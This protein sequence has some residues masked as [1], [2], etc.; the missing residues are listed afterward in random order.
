M[1]HIMKPFVLSTLRRILFC[2]R[3]QVVCNIVD[4]YALGNVTYCN[5]TQLQFISNIYKNYLYRNVFNTYAF[6]IILNT[7]QCIITL[8]KL[9]YAAFGDHNPPVDGKGPLMITV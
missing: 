5:V 9:F 8:S 3:D 1:C 6:I 7:F 2:C 4:Y